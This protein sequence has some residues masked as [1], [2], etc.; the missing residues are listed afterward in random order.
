MGMPLPSWALRAAAV[1][2]VLPFGCLLGVLFW[3]LAIPLVLLIAGRDFPA[4]RCVHEVP[5]YT[6]P[7]GI[8]A[9]IA[10]ALSP[11]LSAGKRLTIMVIGTGLFF[12]LWLV[13]YLFPP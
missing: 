3:L 6:F 13:V 8:A 1:L 2:T 5:A 12:L 10:F 4:W 11:V 7:L 9:A